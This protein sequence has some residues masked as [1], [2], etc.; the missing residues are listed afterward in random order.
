M[1][2]IMLLCLALVLGFQAQVMAHSTKGR[3]KVP[4]DKEV[5]SIDDIAYFFE[6][7]V[8]REFY[9]GKYE[10]PDK[11]FYVNKFLGVDQKGDHAVVRFRTLDISKKFR[12]KDIK[13]GKGTFEDQAFMVRLPSGVWAIDMQGKAPVEMYTYV[14]KW[15]YY[16]KKYVMPVSVV[17]FALGVGTL[18]LLRIRK[19]KKIGSG[20]PGGNTVAPPAA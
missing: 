16:Y 4:L 18:A 11:R 15:G 13:Q 8:Y 2:K 5:L 10:N 20:D 3:L 14:E 1:K 19:R 9:K 17:G 6:S 12:N 7:Y